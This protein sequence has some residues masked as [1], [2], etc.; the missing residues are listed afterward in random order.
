MLIDAENIVLH[1]EKIPPAR[2]FSE[3]YLGKAARS[4]GQYTKVGVGPRLFAGHLP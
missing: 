2:L 1:W 4:R 3:E